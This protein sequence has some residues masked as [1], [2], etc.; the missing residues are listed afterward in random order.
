MLIHLNTIREENTKKRKRQADETTSND[1]NIKKENDV[2]VSGLETRP[3]TLENPTSFYEDQLEE[4]KDQAGDDLESTPP[5]SILEAKL[6][7]HR[8][9]KFEKM[10]KNI[11]LSCLKEAEV[12]ILNKSTRKPQDTIVLGA[13]GAL[14]VAKNVEAFAQIQTPE[15]VLCVGV[16]RSGRLTK[17]QEFLVLGSQKLTELRDKFYCLSD[18]LLDGPD[19]KSGYFFIENVFYNDMRAPTA[20][21]YSQNVI[22]W[23]NQN[24]RYSLKSLGVFRKGDMDAM[25]FKDLIIR[26]NYPYYYVH[27]GNCE[28]VLM[29]KEIRLL[30]SSDNQNLN[31]YPL[32]TFGA[33]MRRRKCR[34]CE[35][36]AAK[37]ATYGDR[38]AQENPCFLCENCYVS[39]HYDKKGRLLYDDF[40]VYDY[41]HE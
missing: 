37:H 7:E 8:I 30:H 11:Q 25:R 22:E 14:P 39:L 1:T 35:V 6:L 27:Q 12:K 3:T 24:N 23:V 32:Q 15:V 28:H 17:L 18:I 5:P 2:E 21:D 31:C 9:Q 26:L 40:E 4:S 20:I 13:E 29:F 10:L 34:V 38:L 16:Y 33:R 36:N 41:H 19:T